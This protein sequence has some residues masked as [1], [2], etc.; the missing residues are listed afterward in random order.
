M[1]KICIG[2][3][4]RESA[5][6]MASAIHV[7]G[8]QLIPKNEIK[9]KLTKYHEDVYKHYAR[10]TKTKSL[11]RNAQRPYIPSAYEISVM[12]EVQAIVKQVRRGG[13]R[14]RGRAN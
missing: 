14:T 10:F 4:H 5:Q 6:S 13:R 9:R 11:K 2:T 8:L 7:R 1:F 12:P 3:F